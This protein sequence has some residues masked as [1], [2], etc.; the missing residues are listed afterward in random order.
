[1]K[2]IL[3]LAWRSLWRNSRRSVITILA[4]F[5]ATFLSIVMRGLQIGT[6]DYNIKTSV[7][8]FT[9]FLQIQNKEFRENESLSKSF[10]LNDSL[11]SILNNTND[12]KA[13]TSRIYSGGLIGK[14]HGTSQGC[15]IFGID[16]VQEKRVSKIANRVNGGKFLSKDS[17]YEI[18]VGYKVL[19]NIDAKI[20][21]EVVVLSSGYDGSMGNLKFRIVGTSKMGSTEMDGMMVM[22]NI[23][24]AKELLAMENRVN[25]I[26]LNIAGMNEMGRIKQNLE[27]S[28]KD[29]SLAVLDWGEL[30]PDMKQSI[31]IDNISG[32]VTMGLLIIIVAFGILN[33]V[34]M[35][36]T[37]RFREFGVMLALGTKNSLLAL[38]VFFETIILTFIGLI[39]GNLFGFILN[40]IFYLN[41]IE[42][43]GEFGKMYEEFGFQ[44]AMYCSLDI[45]I[46]ISTTLTIL[47]IALLVFVYPAF[48][49]SKLEAL[50]GIRYT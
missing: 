37:E 47:I 46:F 28:I 6:Y 22:M 7:E 42:F 10:L 9:G 35:S 8:M 49:L 20:G 15:A 26:A 29:T 16:P 27:Q 32:V 2:L 17:I 36:V 12:I 25:I 24:A 41:P 18:V 11:K 45:S 23:E 19:K 21:D 44:P 33:T 34:L 13:Y 40:Y 4:V 50:K 3:K 5:F 14:N 31:E 38:V 1:V 43:T 48:R 30:M 39:L